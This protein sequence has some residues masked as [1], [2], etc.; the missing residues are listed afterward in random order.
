MDTNQILNLLIAERDRLNQAIAALQGR[1]PGAA[2]K[3]TASATGA[4]GTTGTKRQI[5]RTPEQ[6]AAQAERM[7]AYWANRKK[8]AAKKAAA[9]KKSAS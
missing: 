2:S 5:V 3:G 6:R 7:R 1:S 9:S 4:R 8:G